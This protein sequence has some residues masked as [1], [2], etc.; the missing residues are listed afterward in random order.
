MLFSFKTKESRDIKR[1]SLNVLKKQKKWNKLQDAVSNRRQA[2][3]SLTKCS[4]PKSMQ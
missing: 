1:T 2:N 4:A 3:K